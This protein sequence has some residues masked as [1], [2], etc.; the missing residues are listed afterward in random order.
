MNIKVLFSVCVLW[1]GGAQT[2]PNVTTSLIDVASFNETLFLLLHVFAQ[3]NAVVQTEN[4]IV[5]LSD[6]EKKGYS[7]HRT[8]LVQLS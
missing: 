4:R 2:S 6:Q 5:E 1:G 7:R 8:G 3:G